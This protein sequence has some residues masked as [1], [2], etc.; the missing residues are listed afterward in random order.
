MS[1][2]YV[3]AT[4]AITTNGAC[5]FCASNAFF[6]HCPNVI[7]PWHSNFRR[8]ITTRRTRAAT[9]YRRPHTWHPTLPVEVALN[10]LHGGYQFFTIQLAPA[11]LRP[12]HVTTPWHLVR[13][14]P[15]WSLH[16]APAAFSALGSTRRATRR[17]VP[18]SNITTCQRGL[19]HALG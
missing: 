14:H 5:V 10:W 9:T 17:P 11:S 4:Y 1:I 8:I 7:R 3:S 16:A 19:S 13:N 18:C 12:T 6:R 2:E 15:R